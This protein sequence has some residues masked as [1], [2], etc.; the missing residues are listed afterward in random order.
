MSNDISKVPQNETENINTI[1]AL[2]TVY[3]NTTTSYIKDSSYS[4]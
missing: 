2:N 3:N 1:S 4:Y